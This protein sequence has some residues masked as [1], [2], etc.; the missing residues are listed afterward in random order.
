MRSFSILLAALMLCSCVPATNMP[1]SAPV[2]SIVP[3]SHIDPAMTGGDNVVLPVSQPA[4]WTLLQGGA[5][6]YTG[7]TRP[8]ELT[9]VNPE[10]E[11]VSAEGETAYVELLQS[12]TDALP[13]LPDTG[14]LEAGEVYVHDGTA[15]MVRQSHNRTIYDPADTPALF[16][17]YREDAADVLDWVAG[18]SVLVG[19]RRTYDGTV[20]ECI[21]AHVTQ[22]D[23]TP[24]AVP[25]LWSAVVEP[26]DEWAA[27]V[28]YTIG[29]VV[30]YDGLEYECRQS[31]TSQVGWEP[32]NVLALSL[33]L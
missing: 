21:Q 24:P 18:E 11:L 30:T 20:Y 8:G 1:T 33:P 13:V 10:F 27:G 29:D 17:V 3:V 16:V 5:V 15:V 4:K 12:H 26:S 31:H 9:G 6:A 22:S 32:P 23:W 19:T 14:W 28:A 25:S 7:E 2:S